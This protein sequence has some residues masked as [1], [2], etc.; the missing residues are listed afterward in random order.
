[1]IRPAER[2]PFC[3]M[4]V[5]ASFQSFADARWALDGSRRNCRIFCRIAV[6]PG[7]KTV[8]F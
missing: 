1:M 8:L 7:R 4:P 2:G 6:L 5:F 3:C